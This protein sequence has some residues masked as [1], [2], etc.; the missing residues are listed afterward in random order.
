MKNKKY[1]EHDQKNLKLF[2]IL[3]RCS[4]SVN[5]NISKIFKKFNITE[6]QF[7]VLELLYHKG[8]MRIKAI[9]EKT[10]SSG[11]TMTVII[12]NL[13]KEKLIERKTD[14]ID[15]RAYL[16]S[17]TDAGRERIEGV[18]DKHIKN[19][20]KALSILEDEEKSQIISLLKKLGKFQ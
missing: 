2:L 20:D 3:N 10:F 18:F 1:N 7:N 19:L 6:A 17:L 5:K 15:R 16:I 4:Q 14:P 8:D 11:G 13:E 12:D 9:I